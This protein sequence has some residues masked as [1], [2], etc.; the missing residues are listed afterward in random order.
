MLQKNTYFNSP[1]Y[2]K[3][4]FI[5][6]FDIGVNFGYVLFE[7]NGKKFLITRPSIQFRY[8]EVSK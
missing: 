8:W 3:F 1:E 5:L 4:C 7:K 2:G 6:D